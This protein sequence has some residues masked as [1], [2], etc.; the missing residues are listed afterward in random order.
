M[1]IHLSLFKY[2]C[3]QHTFHNQK[4][5]NTL[6]FFLGYETTKDLKITSKK[7]TTP[8]AVTEG[9]EILERVSLVPILRAGLGMVEAMLELVPMCNVHHL[10]MYRDKGSLVRGV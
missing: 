5:T 9:S 1:S 7:V 8:L 10:G 6:R 3:L 4:R 2:L